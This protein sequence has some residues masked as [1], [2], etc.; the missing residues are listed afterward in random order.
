MSANKTALVVDSIYPF[1][2]ARTT[3]GWPGSG[4]VHATTDV[5]VRRVSVDGTEQVQIEIGIAEVKGQGNRLYRHHGSLVLD[6]TQV[7]ALVR[8]LQNVKAY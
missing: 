3:I 4:F 1:H 5:Q 8:A 7:D 6:P 2:A